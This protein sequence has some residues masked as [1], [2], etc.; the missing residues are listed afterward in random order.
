VS[1]RPKHLAAGGGE[2]PAVPASHRPQRRGAWVEGSLTEGGVL[3]RIPDGAYWAALMVALAVVLFTFM[4]CYQPA[5]DTDRNTTN[6][7]AEVTD[8]R[9]DLD[10]ED[11]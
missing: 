1:R 4:A 11:G 10:C 9:P 6:E 7:C 8:R 5:D 3:H 2:R